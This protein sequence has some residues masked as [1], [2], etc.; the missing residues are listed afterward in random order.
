MVEVA[1]SPITRSPMSLSLTWTVSEAPAAGT[2]GGQLGRCDGSGLQVD[3]R[4]DRSHTNLKRPLV[5][6]SNKL[7]AMR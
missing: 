3:R 6:C 2:G 7:S 5:V 4:A 1:S